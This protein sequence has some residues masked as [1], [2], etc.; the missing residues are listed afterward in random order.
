MLFIAIVNNGLTLAGVDNISHNA[1]IAVILIAG[2]IV[3]DRQAGGV[4]MQKFG[5]G[6][7]Q[8]PQAQPTTRREVS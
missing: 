8:R 5:K 6:L 4:L 2:V 7:R 1:I 3:F